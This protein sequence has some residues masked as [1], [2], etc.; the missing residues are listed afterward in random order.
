MA[1]LLKS[2]SLVDS[3]PPLRVLIVD[4]EPLIRWAI[5]ET[6]RSSGCSAVEA[7]DAC[8][9]L[10]AVA[11]ASVP[12]DVIL[13]DYWLPDSGDLA[14]LA[15]IRSMAPGTPIVMMSARATPDVVAEALRLGASSVMLKPFEMTTVVPAVL[16]A[17][18]HR[19]R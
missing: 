4:D 15:L 3:A 14:T 17:H 16:Q 10:R 12:F 8:A 18:E 11:G 5:G 6:L 19:L 13:L 1:R 2:E 7:K 9:G